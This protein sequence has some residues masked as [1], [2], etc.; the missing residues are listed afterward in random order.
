MQGYELRSSDT[1]LNA[2]FSRTTRQ[3]NTSTP[4]VFHDVFE[5]LKSVHA[6]VNV[7][8]NANFSTRN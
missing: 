2:V 8:K 4:E 7:F 5:T 6:K 3:R 1:S